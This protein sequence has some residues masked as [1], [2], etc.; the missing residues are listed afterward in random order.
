MTSR[1]HHVRGFTISDGEARS[2]LWNQIKADV[3]GQP[4]TPSLRVEA[5]AIGAAILAGLATGLFD[6]AATALAVV[7]EL[8]PPVHPHLAEVGQYTSLRDRWEAIRCPGLSD[9]GP[10]AGRRDL[11]LTTSPDKDHH[12]SNAP[13]HR[14]DPSIHRRRLR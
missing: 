7:L 8:A 11:V 5:P 4:I 1:G 6:S 10:G 12:D 13:R 9:P 3:M 14:S 2:H